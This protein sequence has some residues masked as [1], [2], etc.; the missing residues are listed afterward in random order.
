[1]LPEG[2]LKGFDLVEIA[3]RIKHIELDEHARPDLEDDFFALTR[4]G[5][6]RAWAWIVEV[7]KQDIEGGEQD[8]SSTRWLTMRVEQS[9][10]AAAAMMAADP[11]WA[12]DPVRATVPGG[13]AVPISATVFTGV[14]AVM[15]TGRMRV[16]M[17]MKKYIFR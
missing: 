7:E 15:G 11:I 16:W 14:G 10:L 8:V 5:I 17:R 3:S 9:Q 1:M 4:T 12:A 13:V 2:E 6:L